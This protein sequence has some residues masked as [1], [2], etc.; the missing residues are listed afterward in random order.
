MTIL[1]TNVD[2]LYNICHTVYWVNL[3][4]DSYWF[5]HVSRMLLHYLGKQVYNNIQFIC[6][7]SPSSSS[8]TVA[9]VPNVLLFIHISLKSLPPFINSIV[10]NA[11]R[12]A[13]PCVDQMLSQI[14][15]ASNWRLTHTILHHI[16]YSI[17]NRTKIG[18]IR[19]PDVRSNEFRSFTL[20]ELDRLTCTGCWHT[21]LPSARINV[22]QGSVAAVCRW[23]G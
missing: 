18:T 14:G 12:Q 4:H 3:Q 11:L 23:G 9:N 15:N 1:Y 16:P 20:K 17:V 10:H 6:K 21:V 5:T 19:W 2:R 7:T 22:S 8:I 13:M